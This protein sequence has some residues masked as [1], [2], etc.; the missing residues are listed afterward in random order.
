MMSGFSLTARGLEIVCFFS[1][2][3]K[4]RCHIRL[5]KF[6][7]ALA[8]KGVF[9]RGVNAAL[10]GRSSTAQCNVLGIPTGSG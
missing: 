4:G 8:L 9:E 3:R 7:P 6:N 10:K 5:W 2:C 1:L